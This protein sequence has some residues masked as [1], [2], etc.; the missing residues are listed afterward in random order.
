LERIG[1]ESVAAEL[2]QWYAVPITEVVEL[3]LSWIGPGC[4]S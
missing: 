3:D 1:A 4:R 2:S